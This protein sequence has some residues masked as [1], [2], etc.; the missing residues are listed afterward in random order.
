MPNEMPEVSQMDLAYQI[1]KPDWVAL[2]ILIEEI[3]DELA[4][5]RNNL[6]YC[7]SNWSLAITIFKKFEERQMVVGAPTARDKD[8]HRVILTGLLANGEKL[9]HE[10]M[11]HE[12]IDTNNVG[13]E[14]K[15][16]QS[17]VNELRLNY[18]EWFSDMTGERKKGILGEVFGV[19]AWRRF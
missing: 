2:K 18:A 7:L 19:E 10:L 9:L 12:E 4:Q 15:N 16:V 5:R 8:Y 17:S 3:E 14:L 13:I 6:L 11:K 1:E